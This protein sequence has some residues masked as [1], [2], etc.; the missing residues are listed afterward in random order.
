LA[1]GAQHEL[2]RKIGD[3]EVG[4]AGPPLGRLGA[5]HAGGEGGG[6]VEVGDVEGELQSHR[7]PLRFDYI[8]VMFVDAMA[9]W[10]RRMSICPS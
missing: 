10:D 5:E 4:V 3:G 6:L 1:A 8:D 9:T 2:E 7:T